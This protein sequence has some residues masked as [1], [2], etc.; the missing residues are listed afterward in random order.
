MATP[1]SSRGAGDVFWRVHLP[2]FLSSRYSRRRGALRGLPKGTLVP[3]ARRACVS[4]GPAVVPFFPLEF[5]CAPC[6]ESAASPA[7]FLS[8]VVAPCPRGAPC[9]G[10]GLR[11]KKKNRVGARSWGAKRAGPGWRGCW[12]RCCWATAVAES[13][14]RT[15]QLPFSTGEQRWLLCRLAGAGR[16]TNVCGKIVGEGGAS[17][18]E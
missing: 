8:C 5:F 16:H 4:H 2:A 11:G 1:P 12:P 10:Q 14:R 7:R 18:G 17:V 6:R 13:A 15:C 9:R 3:L